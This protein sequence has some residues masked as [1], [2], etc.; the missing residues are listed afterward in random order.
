MLEMVAV[1][2]ED[3]RRSGTRVD[4]EK[5]FFFYACLVEVGVGA[6]YE[7]TIHSEKT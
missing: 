2:L 6:G 1:V 5:N 4:D 3:V 7:S